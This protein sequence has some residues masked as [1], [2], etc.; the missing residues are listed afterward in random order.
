MG[1]RPGLVM[2]RGLFAPPRARVLRSGA[3]PEPSVGKGPRQ[4]RAW[5]G[6][7]VVAGGAARSLG[8]RDQLVVPV[9]VWD[10]SQRERPHP[11]KRLKLSAPAGAGW[12]CRL[13]RRACDK[14]V[15]DFIRCGGSRRS[16]SAGR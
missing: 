5:Q 11:N 7:M 2:V 4:S 12:R 13:G 8:S 16:L 6:R 14:E 10:V 9:G 1:F 15:V 3:P